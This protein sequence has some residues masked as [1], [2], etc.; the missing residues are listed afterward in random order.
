MSKID[1]THSAAPQLSHHL[2][3]VFDN[4]WGFAHRI[5]RT[6]VTVRYD[7]TPI[8]VN[9]MMNFVLAH[10]ALS[11]LPPVFFYLPVWSKNSRGNPVVSTSGRPPL[12]ALCSALCHRRNA[13]VGQAMETTE[14]FLCLD[15][16][17]LDGNVRRTSLWLFSVKPRRTKSTSTNIPL[18]P[19]AP[20]FP[21]TR[22]YSESSL[23]TSEA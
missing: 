20:I 5:G 6:H 16:F 7:F 22:S 4:Q 2:I 21:R 17:S 1:D 8:G 14:G 13:S 11:V 15:D 18:L 3:T 23:A 9:Q 12:I 19:T 10:L